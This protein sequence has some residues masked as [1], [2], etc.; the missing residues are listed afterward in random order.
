MTFSH[1]N[2][3]THLYL[4]LFLLPWFLMYCV[5]SL[6]FSHRELFNNKIKPE[7]TQQF[8]RSY[9]LPIQENDDLRKIALGVLKDVDMEG[10]F[11]IN[12]RKNRSR[13]IIN[14]FDTWSATR[15]IYY[16]D[17]QRLTAENKKF[18]FRDSL[19]RMH[20]RGGFQQELML[21]DLWAI[22]VD[23]ICVSFL[24]WIA[25][26]IY[27]WWKIK[28]SRSWGFI[29]MASGFLCFLIFLLTL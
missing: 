12:F 25:T 14:R 4:S 17:E 27:M 2:K 21:S 24:I 20:A 9:N 1:L 13:F 16:I 15:L 7:W 28:P 22:L 18:T 8:D 10:P 19:T 3:R 23:I 11:W 5:S 26:G 29:T 6:M